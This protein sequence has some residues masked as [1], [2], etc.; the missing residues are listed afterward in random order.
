[1]R[2]WSIT[3]VKEMLCETAELKKLLGLVTLLFCVGRFL[4]EGNHP[5]DLHHRRKNAG[6]FLMK[7]KEIIPS[8]NSF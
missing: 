5:E 4:T 2:I 1:M 3:R 7:R 8:H 6:S